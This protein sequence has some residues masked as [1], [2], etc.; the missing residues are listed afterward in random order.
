MLYLFYSGQDLPQTYTGKGVVVG[1]QDIGFDLTHPT[2]YST[3]MKDYR[4]KA[5][6]DQLSKDTIGS[7]CRRVRLS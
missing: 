1:I 2:F 7:T 3:N 4:I 5:L 6:W